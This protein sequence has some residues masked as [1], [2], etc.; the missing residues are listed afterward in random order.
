MTLSVHAVPFMLSMQVCCT[1]SHLFEVG[2]FY[3]S[4]SDRLGLWHFVEEMRDGE[5][6]LTIKKKG[7]LKFNFIFFSK[8]ASSLGSTLVFAEFLK[9]KS[10]LLKWV[11]NKGSWMHHASKLKTINHHLLLYF[12]YFS[13]VSDIL[14]SL[15][16]NK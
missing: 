10:N 11:L 2:F 16:Q 9:C 7:F 8:L 5:E 4:K 13:N 14:E 1:F 3:K 15:T 6:S 12:W